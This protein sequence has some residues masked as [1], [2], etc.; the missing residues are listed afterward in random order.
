MVTLSLIL[1]II[2]LFIL[3]VFIFRV[4]EKLMP[5]NIIDSYTKEIKNLVVSEKL[6]IARKKIYTF[7]NIGILLARERDSLAFGKFLEAWVD[8]LMFEKTTWI[9]NVLNYEIPRIFKS[10]SKDDETIAKDG[11]EKLEKIVLDYLRKKET[12]KALGV[13]K[14]YSSIT[15]PLIEPHPEL[16]SHSLYCLHDLEQMSNIVASEPDVISEVSIATIENIRTIGTMSGYK[17][18][19]LVEEAID[20][21]YDIVNQRID[22]ESVVRDGVGCI[23][24]L[25]EYAPE[26]ANTRLLHILYFISTGASR[27]PSMPIEYKVKVVRGILPAIRITESLEASELINIASRL[28][29]DDENSSKEALNEIA[30]VLKGVVVHRRGG[31]LS[32][33][34][35]AIENAKKS[36]EE[37]KSNLP[38]DDFGKKYLFV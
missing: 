8:L 10:I 36:S 27:I 4:K 16:V 1:F 2:V 29:K 21:T 33:L 13:I 35:A 34:K 9:K 6:E 26:K 23:V 15:E 25:R 19:K 7:G 11:L 5:E 14:V 17:N 37:L 3:I 20:R 24:T 22:V 32:W 31:N 38:I 28:L 30:T 18:T 12:E